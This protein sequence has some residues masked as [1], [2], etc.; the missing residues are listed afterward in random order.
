[1]IGY[2]GKQV[3]NEKELKRHTTEWKKADSSK[4]G[5]TWLELNPASVA[6]KSTATC[7]FSST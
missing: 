5:T 1:M 3:L 4:G 7:S 6:P 2:Q